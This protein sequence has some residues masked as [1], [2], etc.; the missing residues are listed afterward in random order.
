MMLAPLALL[1]P[2]VAT[3]TGATTPWTPPAPDSPRLLP[4]LRDTSMPKLAYSTWV[5]WYMNGGLNETSLFD[6]QHA[7]AAWLDPHPAR[8][9]LAGLR[10]HVRD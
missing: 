2:A 10:H 5:G 6:G 8:L 3:L 9:R 1:L 7:A 4:F